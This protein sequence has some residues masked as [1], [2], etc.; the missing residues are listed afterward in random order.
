MHWQ[1]MCSKP[2]IRRAK[3]GETFTLTCG[4]PLRL[5]IDSSYPYP[6]AAP[7]K[8]GP[9][10]LPMT[11]TTTAPDT[12]Q[13]SNTGCGTTIHTGAMPTHDRRVW[14]AS[15]EAV[16]PAVVLLPPEYF[17]ERQRLQLDAIPR[18][19]ECGCMT[20]GVGCGIC[21][22]PLG[23]ITA[24]CEPHFTSEPL[25][26]PTKYNFL[27]EAVSPPFPPIKRAERACEIPVVAPAPDTLVTTTV[28]SSQPSSLTAMSADWINVPR[29]PSP[30]PS[31]RLEAEAIQEQIKYQEEWY[32]EQRRAGLARFT[33]AQKEGEAPTTQ[34]ALRKRTRRAI[35]VYARL[36][37][38]E[39]GVSEVER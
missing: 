26:Y 29:P 21:G 22:N 2:L 25:M 15:G 37:R 6:R 12:S 28:A 32:E 38:R 4:A 27:P 10:I 19:A 33:N 3:A 23:S 39:D 17:T 18:I 1:S 35:G 8:S 30:T 31:E 9:R 24:R 13:E 36:K 14:Y 7:R 11:S 34:E 16:T 20:V 5:P